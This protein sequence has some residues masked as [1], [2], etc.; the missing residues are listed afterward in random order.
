MAKFVGTELLY[1]F[2]SFV[3]Q[4]ILEISTS[5]V[6]ILRQGNRSLLFFI[7]IAKETLFVLISNVHHISYGTIW[8]GKAHPDRRV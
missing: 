2:R 8:G 5:T 6:H 1:H 3:R 4:L 7:P